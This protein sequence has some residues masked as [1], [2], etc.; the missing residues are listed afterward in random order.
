[1]LVKLNLSSIKLLK[2]AKSGRPGPVWLDVALEVQWEKIK[3]SKKKFKFKK[4]KIIKINLNLK[5]L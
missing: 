5:K 1:M 2:I 4:L 3:K